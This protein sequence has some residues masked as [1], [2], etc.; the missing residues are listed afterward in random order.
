[1]NFLNDPSA[2]TEFVSR[3]EA[4]DLTRQEW[5]HAAHVAIGAYYAYT[6]TPEEALASRS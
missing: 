4:G 6:R 3:W 5:T 1:M 2:L